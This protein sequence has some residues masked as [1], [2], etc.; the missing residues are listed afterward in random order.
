MLPHPFIVYQKS[1]P[2]LLSEIVFRTGTNSFPAILLPAGY[3]NNN[4]PDE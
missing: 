4:Q 3:K 2:V 1:I